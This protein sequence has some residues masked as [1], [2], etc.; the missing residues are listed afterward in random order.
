MSRWR[1]VGILVL[2]LAWTT[3]N[4]AAQESTAAQ[5]PSAEKQQAPAEKQPS[6]APEKKPVIETAATR[7]ASA[8]NVLIVRTHGSEIPFETIVSTIDGWG[9]FTLVEARDKADLIIEIASSGGGDSGVQVSSSSG[10]SP[11][12]GREQ[13]SSSSRK[14]LTPTQITMAVF[15]ARNKRPL[16]SETES[17]KFA[18][19]EKAK[20]NNLVDAA[21]R[22]A[23]KFHERVEPAAKQ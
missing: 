10:V 3:G 9:R 5:Q 4:A 7:L 1:S 18:M 12:T 17:V 23:A 22:L 16:W 6:P 15:D 19:K 20:E 13:R 14:D 21:E 8:R 2:A 11:E